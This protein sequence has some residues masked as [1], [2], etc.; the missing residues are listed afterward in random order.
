MPVPSQHPATHCLATVA[1]SLS[2]SSEG[3]AQAQRS[4]LLGHDLCR[5]CRASALQRSAWRSSALTHRLATMQPLPWHPYSIVQPR[6][7]TIP[8]P[9]TRSPCRSAHRVCLW[10]YTLCVLQCCMSCIVQC[11]LYQCCSHL[12]R[13]SI[14]SSTMTGQAFGPTCAHVVL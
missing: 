3:Q 14:W 8:W 5:R 7:D 13:Q 9:A 2:S 1:C 4:Q 12:C 11:K 10:H 6:W